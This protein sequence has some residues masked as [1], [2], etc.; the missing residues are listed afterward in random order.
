MCS[1]PLKTTRP[2]YRLLLGSYVSAAYYRTA[3]SELAERVHLGQSREPVLAAWVITESGQKMLGLAPAVAR[4]FGEE[5]RRTRVIPHTFGER[6]VL[7]MM[8]A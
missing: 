7:K 6:A 1:S 5:R 3:V 8:F 4:L 2:P